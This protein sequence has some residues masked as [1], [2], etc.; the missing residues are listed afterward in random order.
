PIARLY[1]L[2][3][4]RGIAAIEVVIFHAQIVFGGFSLFNRGYLCVDLFFILSGFV[5]TLSAE[6]RMKSGLT[7]IQFFRARIVRLWPMV[8]IGLILGTAVMLAGHQTQGL[9]LL[10]LAGALS[11]PALWHN[12]DPQPSMFPVNSPQWSIYA[13]LI[14]N[15][16]HGLVLR[17]LNNFGLVAVIVLSGAALAL[18]VPART[19]L[20]IGAFN[21]DV[22]AV[23]PVIFASYTIGVLLA[24]NFNPAKLWSGVPWWFALMLP[25]L[26]LLGL[27]AS[28]LDWPLGDLLAIM[29]LL[30]AAF[31]LATKVAA[32]L[33]ARKWLAALGDM[34]FPLY[35]VHFPIMQGVALLGNDKLHYFVGVGTALLAALLVAQT[36]IQTWRPGRPLLRTRKA[37]PVT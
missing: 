12:V 15:L 26:I 32:P 1:M 10:I 7:A 17:R 2:D 9:A 33:G 29:V 13:E 30:P 31:W 25:T 23:L 20:G 14:A 37:V 22:L 5:L 4:I 18:L 21:F 36:N 16:A 8:V 3:G 35:A 11:I 19:N 28:G 34:S 6:P 24:R 27:S